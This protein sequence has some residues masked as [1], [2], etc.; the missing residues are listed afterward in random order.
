MYFWVLNSNDLKVK[1]PT[2]QIFS[3]VFEEKQVNVFVQREDLNHPIIQ[4]NKLRK[5][6][7]NLLNARLKGNK[8]LLTFGGAFS[9]HI[10]ALAQA[11]KEFGFETIGIIRGEEMLPLNST[12]TAAKMLGMHLEYMNRSVYKLKHTQDV[13]DTLRNNFGSFYLIPEGG[14][15]YYA[16]NGCMEIIENYEEFDY[17][18]CPVGTGGT[19]AG[20]TISNQNK[21]KIIGFPALRG[22]DFLYKEISNFINLVLYTFSIVS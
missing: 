16:V 22:G 9:N 21:S 10:L 19:I 4:G 1:V 17:I 7:Y 5:L 3:S 11:G 14:S 18:C 12:L 13:I 2:Q 8:T 20:I 6:H 15:N